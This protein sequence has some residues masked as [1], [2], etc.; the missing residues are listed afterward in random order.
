MTILDTIGNTR[1]FPLE[2]IVPAGSAR[3]LLKLEMERG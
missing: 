1:L 2:R 3:I